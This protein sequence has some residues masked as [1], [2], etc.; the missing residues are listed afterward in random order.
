MREIAGK[1][2]MKDKERENAI[3][4]MEQIAE[5][6]GKPKMFDCKKGNT[7]WYDV[8]DIITNIIKKGG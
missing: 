6:I 2:S 8:E 7:T 4:I 5:Y 3:E 1:E